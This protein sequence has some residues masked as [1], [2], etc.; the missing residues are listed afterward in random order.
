[1]KGKALGAPSRGRCAESASVR[2]EIVVVESVVVESVVERIGGIS[3][4]RVGGG[5]GDEL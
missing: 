5:G 1:M 3:G 2:V 4:A